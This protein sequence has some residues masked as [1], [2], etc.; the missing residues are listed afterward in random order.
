MINREHVAMLEQLGFGGD[1]NEL[2]CYI[3]DL[4]SAME[5][6]A[7]EVENNEYDA[8]IALLKEVKPDSYLLKQNWGEDSAETDGVDGLLEVVPMR[9]IT[10]ITSLDEAQYFIDYCRSI[11][12]PNIPIN[13]SFK[14]NGHG[15]RLVYEH[16]SFKYARTRGRTGKGRD[17]SR[18]V[19]LA[20]VPLYVDEFSGAECIEVRAEAVIKA[21]D[22]DAHFSN[23][24][25][26]KL[27]CI[28]HL[29]ADSTPDSELKYLDICC[30]RIIG[31]DAGLSLSE[32][33]SL[34]GAC[35]FTVVHNKTFSVPIGKVRDAL[36]LFINYFT[37]VSENSEVIPYDTDGVVVA[38]DDSELFY[39]AP[40]NKNSSSANVAIKMGTKWATN[41]FE[42]TIESITWTPNK[43]F[44]TPKAN[45]KPVKMPNGATV[46]V[47]PLYNAG[48]MNNY[49]LVSGSRV[50][51]RFGGETGVTLCDINGNS[52]T[53]RT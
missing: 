2:E 42:S 47:V 6:G 38:I 30:Y 50:H 29:L 20:G 24:Y 26:H 19:K 12:L 45:I 32:E 8:Y 7:V 35:G 28:T 34:L 16:G 41:F 1:A 14:L 33:I 37:E 17:I 10:T 13:G 21:V 31:L 18:H 52:V 49:N 22:F 39:N 5:N 51:F 46:S 44:Y 53:K 9:S 43:E 4:N 3:E 48:V 27:S 40:P 23:E 25:K 15:I 36:Q 11:G